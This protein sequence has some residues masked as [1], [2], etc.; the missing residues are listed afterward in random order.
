M[1]LKIKRQLEIISVQENALKN[2]EFKVYLQPKIDLQKNELVGAEAL[3]RWKRS[4][5]P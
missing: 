1:L 4:D 5:E 3:I 2:R